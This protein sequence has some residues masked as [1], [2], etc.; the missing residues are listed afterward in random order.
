MWLDWA[1]GAP[2]FLAP[3][4]VFSFP[5]QIL[6]SPRHQHAS[7]SGS[8]WVAIDYF[9]SPLTRSFPVISGSI[10]SHSFRTHPCL[11]PR[12]SQFSTAFEP[13]TS[14]HSPTHEV[15]DHRPSTGHNQLVGIQHPNPTAQQRRNTVSANSWFGIAAAR[16]QQQGDLISHVEVWVWVRSQNDPKT[17]KSQ[18]QTALNGRRV[19][20]SSPSFLHP[21]RPLLPSTYVQS[22][23]PAQP[24]IYSSIP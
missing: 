23:Q 11:G 20:F 16:G 10:E 8:P 15:E 17:A 13:T 14:L 5:S 9:F 24:S 2:L 22:S 18:I 7:I 4:F 19:F 6:K 3:L 1:E 12:R 21:R